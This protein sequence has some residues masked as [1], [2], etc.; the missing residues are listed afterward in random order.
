MGVNSG[1]RKAEGMILDFH[2]EKHELHE[3]GGVNPRSL[4]KNS[5]GEGRGGSAE[6]FGLGI[7]T[8]S[9]FEI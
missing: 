3:K 5:G 2:H 6:S 1:R 9:E 7:G 8:R 4:R